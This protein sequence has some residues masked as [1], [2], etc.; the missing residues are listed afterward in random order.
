MPTVSTFEST[1]Q[2]SQLWLHDLMEIGHFADEAQAYVALRSVLQALRDRLTIEEAAHLAAQLPLM[3][4]GAFYEGWD[5]ARNPAREVKSE[6]DFVHTVAE[7][8][9]GAESTFNV[10]KGIRAVF[11]LLDRKI[12][13][14]EIEDVKGSMPAKL[15]R[16]WP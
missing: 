8:T 7:K 4:R 6:E 15:Q 14:G 13:A 2:K 10:P 11:Q 16:L 5:P 1:Y 12:S 3:I 9:T